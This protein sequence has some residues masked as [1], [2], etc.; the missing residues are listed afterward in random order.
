MFKTLVATLTLVLAF[1]WS[2]VGLAASRSVTLAVSGMTCS[3]CP[4]TV[5]KALS[6]VAGVAS[7]EVRFEQKLATVS[8][9]DT[10]A[11]PE[12]LIAAIEQAGFAATVQQ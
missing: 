10:K 7:V 4:I 6:R 11:T 3:T 9:D 1:C 8:Y 2:S 5:K 12:A